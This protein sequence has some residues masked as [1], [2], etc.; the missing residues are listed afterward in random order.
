VDAIKQNKSYFNYETIK[1]MKQNFK[2]GRL[3]VYINLLA[4]IIF[5]S[6]CVKDYRDGETNFSDVK[7][8]VIIAE[9]GLSGTSFGAAAITFPGTDPSD[10]AHFHVNYAATNVAPADEAVTLAIDP[11]AITSYNSDS[12]GLQYE[13]MPDSDFTFTATSVTV[14]K[15]NNYTAGIPVIFYPDKIDGSKN[16]MLP[17]SITAVPSGSTM[18]INQNTIYYHAIGNPIAGAYN[19]CEWFRWNATDTTGPPTYDVP[20]ST[21]FNPVTP[22]QVSIQSPGNGA[23]YILSF[24]NNNGVLSNFSVTLDPASYGNFGLGTLTT[25]P[26]IEIADPINGIYR[27]RYAYNNTSGLARVAVD[28]FAK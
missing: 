10:T 4:A 16:Y 28:Q 23:V 5:S 7:P 27:F 26:I 19:N 24:D 6:S 14:S 15:G 13:L 25:A 1:Y 12:L 11:N 20:G 22:T 9:G 8:M 3:I 21:T 18:S 17:I 2:S